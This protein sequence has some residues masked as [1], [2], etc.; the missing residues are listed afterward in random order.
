MIKIGP[1]HG[2]D[3]EDDGP[4]NRIGQI[5]QMDPAVRCRQIPDPHETEDAGAEQIDQHGDDADA[6]TADAA[7]KD[8]GDAKDEL[9][10]GDAVQ[11]VRANPYDVDIRIEDRDELGLFSVV[12]KASF[13]TSGHHRTSHAFRNGRSARAS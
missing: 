13:G 12:R 9:Q 5:D 8:I 7:H 2:Q 6:K 3:H 11:P 10:R 4:G 1:V